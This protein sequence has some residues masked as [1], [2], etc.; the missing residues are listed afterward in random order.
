MP[1]SNGVTLNS[2]LS[3]ETRVSELEAEVQLLRS[4]ISKAKGLND[5][6]WEAVVQRVVAD[7]KK[8]T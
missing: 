2:Q 3:Q 6:M 8:S 1:N 7:S 5:A 4:Q